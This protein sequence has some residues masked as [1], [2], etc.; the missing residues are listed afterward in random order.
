MRLSR[1]GS[2]RGCVGV[3]VWP[4]FCSVV[5]ESRAERGANVM[6]L[7]DDKGPNES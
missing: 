6:Q 5:T 7:D 4:A 1:E 2:G 3:G